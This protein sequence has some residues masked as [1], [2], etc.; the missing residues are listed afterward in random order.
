MLT[1]TE[2]R[3]SM[4]DQQLQEFITVRQ[5]AARAGVTRARIL[6]LLQQRPEYR[7]VYSRVSPALWERLHYHAFN[8]RKSIRSVVR[9]LLESYH[10]QERAREQ[11]RPTTGSSTGKEE[12]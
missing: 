10:Q 3:H 8:K 11:T 7:V 4:S 1:L 5:A 2:R 6:Q 9:D 12:Q